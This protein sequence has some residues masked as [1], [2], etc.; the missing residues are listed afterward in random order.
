MPKELR[1]SYGDYECRALAGGEGP[2][3]L[4]LLHGYSFT[5]EVWAEVSLLDRLDSSGIAYVA[6]DM[7]YGMRSE[8]TK[9][10][11]DMVVNISFLEGL[12]EKWGVGEDSLV[13]LGASLGGHVALLYA[14]KWGARGLVL[15]APV[16]V[17]DPELKKA[18]ERLRGLPALIVY[19]DRDPIVS[20]DEM[21]RL[22]AMFGERA[23]LSI[24]EGAGHPAYLYEKDRF[25]REVMDFLREL[26]L[27]R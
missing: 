4:V 13:L 18:G 23:R 1:V 5:S 9:R 12:V 7:P 19:G 24:Y 10:T 11:R 16:G 26:G 8:C 3:Q 22:K 20:L 21:E 14:A 17:D 27:A 15:V 2:P 25:V 6:L